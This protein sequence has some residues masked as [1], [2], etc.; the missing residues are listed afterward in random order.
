MNKHSIYK[1][2]LSVIFIYCAVHG[3][4]ANAA[5][6]CG[7]PAWDKTIDNGLLLWKDCTTGIWQGR[8]STDP[9]TKSIRLNATLDS[10]AGFTS[11][12]AISIENSDT[13]D[14][15]DPNQLRAPL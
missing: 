10:D 11:I 8:V 15:S 2:F 3:S 14:T 7:V 9:V 12:N 6:A 1:S 5:D 13:F 4:M